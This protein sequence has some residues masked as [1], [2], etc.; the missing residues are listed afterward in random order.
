MKNQAR[1]FLHHVTTKAVHI[2]NG[3]VYI[4]NYNDKTEKQQQDSQEQNK[5]YKKD[6]Q[7]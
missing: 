1:K 6:S 2:Y 3:P 5:N 4:S 7:V